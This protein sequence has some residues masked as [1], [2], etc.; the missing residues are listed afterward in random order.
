VYFHFVK[1]DDPK[2]I[3][4]LLFL[5]GHAETHEDEFGKLGFL[6]LDQAIGEYDVEAKVGFIYIFWHD[7]AHFKGAFHLSK[8]PMRLD[9]LMANRNQYRQN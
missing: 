2:K 7:S 9:A 1:D 4:I 3:A 6:I 8:M 5:S